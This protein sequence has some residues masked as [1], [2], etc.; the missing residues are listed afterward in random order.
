MNKTYNKQFNE[1]YY[2]KT[3]ASGLKVI[4]FDKH[5]F[6]NNFFTLITPYGSSDF[7]QKDASG[8]TYHLPPGVAHFLE[9]RMFDYKGFDV[10]E[11]FTEL[12]ASSNASTGYDQTQY[13]FST[14]NSDFKEPL[15]LLLDYVFDLTIPFETVEKEKGIIIEELMMYDA[16]PDFRLYFGA[17][18]N[19]YNELP[20]REEIGGSVASVSAT[21]LEDLELAYKLNYHPEQMYL[22]GATNNDIAETFAYIENIMQEKTFVEYAPM[23]RDYLAE[24]D[25]VRVAYEEVEMDIN[26][27]KVAIAYKFRHNV[28][29][30][31]EIDKIENLLDI[32]FDMLFS[33]V[34]PDYQDWLDQGIINDY[35]DLDI[36]VDSIFGHLVFSAET[37]NISEFEALIESVMANDNQYI[38]EAKFKQLQKRFIGRAIMALEKPGTIAQVY[39]RNIAQTIDIFESINQAKSF[40]LADLIKLK[41]SLDLLAHKSTYVIKAK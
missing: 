13:Y 2:S 30:V 28:E 17:I 14:T 1:T 39:G 31:M 18:K 3:L 38:S 29:D 10:M 15:K 32:Y 12:G 24:V 34:N 23:E 33:S 25:Q 41:D 21:T 40:T 27:Q 36:T 8:N 37:D 5:E 26:K 11:R 22:V 7:K 19:L 20:Y 6:H 16:M 35:F 9:H 4:L